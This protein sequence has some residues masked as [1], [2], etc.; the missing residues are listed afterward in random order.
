MGS[1]DGGCVQFFDKLPTYDAHYPIDP[2]TL[3]KTDGI[4]GRYMGSLTTPPCTE[5]VTWTV[6]LWDVSLLIPYRLKS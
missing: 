2:V 1:H 4:Y 3:I 6:M 5:N